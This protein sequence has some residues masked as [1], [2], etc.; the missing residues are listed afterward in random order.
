VRWE[1]AALEN[2]SSDCRLAIKD[3]LPNPD[4]V[5]VEVRSQE[6]DDLSA[7]LDG[8]LSGDR[9]PPG[10]LCAVGV[11]RHGEQGEEAGIFPSNVQLW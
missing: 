3:T 9:Q 4:C 11:F 8:D 2:M 5:V 10:R 6:C 7:R 1:V